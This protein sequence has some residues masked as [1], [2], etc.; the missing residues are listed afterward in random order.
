MFRASGDIEKPADYSGGRSDKDIIKYLRK[1]TEP[2]YV[3]VNTAAELA[4]FDDKEG[5]EVLG[6]FSSLDSDEAKA[7][8]ATAEE[9]R[10]DY[11]FGVATNA[12]FATQFGVA[13]PALVLFKSEAG[14]DVN[15]ATADAAQVGSTA[16]QK[17]WI[18]GEAFELVGE[19]G[20]ENFQKYLDR[21]LPLV[22]AFVDYKPESAA[23]TKDL[24]ATVGEAA[25]EFKG[26]LS[27][28]KLDGHRWAE[29]AKHFGL[30]GALPGIVVE[31]REANK[32]FV[33]PEGDAVTAQALKDH[34]AGF[35]AGTLKATTK[36]QPEPTDNNAPVTVLVGTSFERIVLDDTKDVLVEFYGEQTKRRVG[37]ERAA[38]CPSVETHNAGVAFFFLCFQLLGADTAR[39]LVRLIHA[40]MRKEGA[41]EKARV[42]AQF[43][44]FLFFF[45]FSP[46]VRS[47]W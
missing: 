17:A 47:P 23:A 40:Q 14:A 8:L 42:F 10:N 43:C 32:N 29:H 41:E 27:V 18:Q 20:P 15:V 12:D 9:L 4:A 22:W 2:S 46:E 39:L 36:S 34:F 3:N 16:A 28:V 13:A 45:V 35:L 1:Q 26:R 33:F 24:L 11:T 7:F 19:I 25:K 30:S 38:A 21:G 6:I 44:L 37:E 5:V 31:D